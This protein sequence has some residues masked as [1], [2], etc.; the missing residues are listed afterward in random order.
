MRKIIF[1]IGMIFLF[2]SCGLEKKSEPQIILHRD[3]VVMVDDTE[4]GL[5]QWSDFLNS[6][7]LVNL[8]TTAEGKQYYGSVTFTG[9]NDV[10]LNRIQT[11]KLAEPVLFTKKGATKFSRTLAERKNEKARAESLVKVSDLYKSFMDKNSLGVKKNSILYQPIAKGINRLASSK[12]DEKIL[13]ILSDMIE[14]SGC[15]NF[16]RATAQNYPKIIADLIACSKIT[17]TPNSG[18]KVIVLFR[19]NSPEKD[20]YFVKSM[21]IWD[22]LFQKAGI[23]YEVLPN[24]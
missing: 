21:E 3:I 9:I 20:K 5:Y 8:F 23:K 7:D 2:V 1:F 24:L 16:Y 11:A 18:V 12:A 13:I 15:G 14:N 6:D 17:I 19:T 4:G 10:S 22:I